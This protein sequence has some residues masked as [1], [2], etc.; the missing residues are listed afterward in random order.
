MGDLEALRNGGTTLYVF[1]NC[2]VHQNF[3]S[4][5]GIRTYAI[6][7]VVDADLR[8]LLA[9]LIVIPY[10]CDVKI[11][12]KNYHFRFCVSPRDEISIRIGYRTRYPLV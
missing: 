12:A 6:Q 4:I 10:N 11:V 7:I 3:H 5:I 2:L 8:P 9:R 1:G